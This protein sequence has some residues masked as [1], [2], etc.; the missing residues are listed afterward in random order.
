MEDDG[1][2]YGSCKVIL[3]DK[4]DLNETR[5]GS[6]IGRICG[7]KESLVRR[8][9]GNSGRGVGQMQMNALIFGV[10]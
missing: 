4:Y 10:S 9:A 5:G 8:Q 1:V 3:L 6:A 7:G 2:D